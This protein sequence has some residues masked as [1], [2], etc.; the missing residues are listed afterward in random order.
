[1][2]AKYS[3][4]GYIGLLCLVVSLLGWAILTMFVHWFVITFL[5]L[6]VLGILAFASQNVEYI[7]YRL[8]KKSTAAGANMF[9]SVVIFGAIVVFL[10]ILLTRHSTIFDMTEAKKFSLASQTIQ[11]LEGMEEPINML[12][13]ENP[14][15]PGATTRAKE[16]MDL[17]K[18]YSDELTSEIIDPERE[19]EKVEELAPVSLGAIY[20]QKGA[21]HE[22]VSP[23]DENNLTNAFMKLVKGGSRVVY[24]TTGH[25]E[26]SIESQETNGLFAMNQILTEEGYEPKELQLYTM[27]SV[28][29]DAVAVVIAGP[30]KPFFEPEFDALKN[31]LDQG[32][33]VFVMLDPERETGLDQ[34][35]ADN[36][37]IEFGNDWIVE[38][39]PM[40]KLFGG[41]PNAPMAAEMGDHPIMQ[42]FK[43]GMQAMT[44]PIVQSVKLKTSMPE[45]ITGTEILK[46][47]ESSWI[48]K[49]LAAIRQ[50]GT[51]GKDP[52]DEVGPISL[53]VAVSKPIENAGAPDEGSA[54]D[55]NSEDNV[56]ELDA[57]P[58]MRIV[59]FGDANFAQNS[60]YRSSMDLFTNTVNWLS[61]QEDL[62]SIRPKDDSGQPIM[63]SVVSAKMLFYTSLIITPGIV[64]IFGAFICLR[65]RYR[66]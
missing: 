4:L 44:F 36:Y 64:A 5:V 19:P 39:N 7:Q 30:K 18:H 2:E 49:D 20:L 17:Y 23:V 48:E 58:E 15:D 24:F 12:Y 37:G 46:T 60:N 63:V 51:V 9:V 28:P 55:E 32:G 27:E 3:I 8:T 22:K 1:M 21:A 13:L 40:M 11:L 41:S 52:G 50:S 33:K 16:L 61:Q 14:T 34:F 29:D 35:F 54:D 25:D 26:S 47:S 6:G 59:A 56:E 38:Y 66:G 53:A 57:A 43:N 62:I 31:Y 42:A 10:Q 65:R 45:G